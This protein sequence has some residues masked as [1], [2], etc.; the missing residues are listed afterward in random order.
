MDG[1][2]DD[3]PSRFGPVTSPLDRYAH[4]PSKTRKML[5][6]IPEEV[7]DFITHLREEDV[8]DI[9]EFIRFGRSVRVLTRFGRGAVIFLVG[10]FTA[11]IV[12]GEKAALAW[13]WITNR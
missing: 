2:D 8:T 9:Q 1:Q 11:A 10:G 7:A 12:F 13:K 3:P 4:L 6:S 5:E